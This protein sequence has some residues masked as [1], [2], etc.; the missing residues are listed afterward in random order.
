MSYHFG[1][2]VQSLILFM[3]FETTHLIHFSDLVE[4]LLDNNF[5]L[6]LNTR[7]ESMY[8]QIMSGDVVQISP[9][10]KNSIEKGNIVVYRSG[11]SF[12]CHRLVRTYHKDNLL[13]CQTRGDSHTFNDPEFSSGNILGTVNIIEKQNKTISRIVLSAIS[14]LLMK[15]GKIHGFVFTS[16]LSIKKKLS[17]LSVFQQPQ[18]S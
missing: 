3:K 2:T 6:K 17:V 12:V 16:F 9:L 15:F 7:G 11:S 10:Q 18:K 13:F 5:T 4:N 8:P 1:Q 14:N